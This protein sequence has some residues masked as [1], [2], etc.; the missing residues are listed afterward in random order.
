MDHLVK[1]GARTKRAI[2]LVM[3]VGL[4][5]ATGCSS[6]LPP[7][8]YLIEVATSAKAN[9]NSPIP[10]TLVAVRDPKLFEQIV[11]LSA[12]QWYEQREQMRRDF[13]SGTA[14]S[15][16]DWEFVPGQAPPPI[17]I[18]IDGQALGG[19]LFANYRSPG[20]HRFRIG[21]AQR[22]RIDLLDDGFA[23]TPLDVPED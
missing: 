21:A 5:W 13:P 2:L 14:F 20:D 12:K 19:I 9:R 10:V 16:W 22:M 1:I 11:K 8:R 6:T 15:E 17:F 23:I 7:R 3:A 4:S 18:E